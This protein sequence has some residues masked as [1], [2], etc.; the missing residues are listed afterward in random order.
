MSKVIS[1][2][3]CEESQCK[4]SDQKK[5]VHVGDECFHQNNFH[6][7][8]GIEFVKR[9]KRQMNDDLNTRYSRWGM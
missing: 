5:H 9:P 3:D 1:I 2:C 8:I 7:K 6:H 4:I